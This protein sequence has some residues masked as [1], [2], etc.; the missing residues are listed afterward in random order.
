MSLSSLSLSELIQ[1][2][3][4]R[5]PGKAI[6]SLLKSSYLSPFE[7]SHK[8]LHIVLI[9]SYVHTVYLILVEQL[10][11][12]AGSIVEPCRIRTAH[13]LVTGIHPS[14]SSALGIFHMY[15]SDIRKIDLS[16]VVYLDYGK[17]MSVHSYLDGIFVSRTALLIHVKHI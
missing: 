16:W 5:W 7:K 11:T 2:Q 9:C 4:A 15:E 13:L 17:I 1:S 8:T 14:G 6:I 12:I 3:E 10:S